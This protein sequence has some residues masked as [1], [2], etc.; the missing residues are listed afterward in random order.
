LANAPQGIPVGCADTASDSEILAI[1]DHGLSP[2]GPPLLE[3]LLDARGPVV[4]TES[5]IDSRVQD[6]STEFTWGTATDST[7]ENEGNLIR[8][9]EIQ[10]VTNDSFQ[11]H[12]T[13][14]RPIENAGFRY[15]ELAEGQLVSVAG[16]QLGAGERAG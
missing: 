8:S 14:L 6:S 15:F 9:T 11:P 1:A 2:Q 10:V 12:A 5:G 3:V 13:G 16:A 4:T 7:L